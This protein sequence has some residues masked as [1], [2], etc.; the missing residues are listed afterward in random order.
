MS[1]KD[2]AKIKSVV[3]QYCTAANTD[4]LDA[5][6][7]TLDQKVLWMPPDA[8]R[9]SGRKAV[10][11]FSKERFFDPYRINLSVKLNNVKVYGAKAFTSGVFSLDLTPKAGGDTIRATGKHMHEFRKQR[12]G[13]WKYGELIWNYDRPVA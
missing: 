13:S 3:R 6:Q 1:K 5:W 12:D 10:A 2:I 9:L 7:K 4:N 8:S 11:A